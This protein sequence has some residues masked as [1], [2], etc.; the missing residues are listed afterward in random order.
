MLYCPAGCRT[1]LNSAVLPGRCAVLPPCCHH[2]QM[3]RLS[4]CS[5]QCTSPCSFMLFACVL[6]EDI[7]CACSTTHKVF[8]C[9]HMRLFTMLKKAYCLFS[10]KVMYFAHGA[11]H[12]RFPVL[13]HGAFHHASW[14]PWHAVIPLAH[15]SVLVKVRVACMYSYERHCSSCPAVLCCIAMGERPRVCGWS[16]TEIWSLSMHQLMCVGCFGTAA[17][18]SHAPVVCFKSIQG[19]ALLSRWHLCLHGP[20]VHYEHSMHYFEGLLCWLCVMSHTSLPPTASSYAAVSTIY[21]EQ[22]AYICSGCHW[23]PCRHF[24]RLDQQLR[25]SAQTLMRVWTSLSH[26]NVS[27]CAWLRFQ[28]GYVS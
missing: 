25:L 6:G 2:V 16:M 9:L 17:P 8:L 20:F 18:F 12:T 1:A 23:R 11:Q 27:F 21:L 24:Y 14:L 13:A 5:M 7:Y 4:C 3:S 28:A 19:A 15:C 26:K 22:L 10:E